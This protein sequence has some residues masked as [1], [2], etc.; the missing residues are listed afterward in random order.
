MIIKEIIID[1]MHEV[2]KV[3]VF[4]S[5]VKSGSYLIVAIFNI[6]REFK[7]HKVNGV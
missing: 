6:Y 4:I 3:L 5:A 1:E 2:R 7:I